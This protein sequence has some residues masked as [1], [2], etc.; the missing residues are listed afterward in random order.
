MHLTTAFSAAR[1]GFGLTAAATGLATT[2]LAATGTAMALAL[3]L[4]A[5]L[6]ADPAAA[7]VKGGVLR[8]ALETD[9][10]GF[11][12][13][14]GGVFGQTGEIVART[15]E[16]PLIGW[17]P[18]TN[19]PEPLLAVSWE[20][21]EDQ[22][23]WTFKLREGVKYHDGSDF[24]AEDV[25]KHYNRILDPAMKSRSRT[26]IATIQ[27]VEVIDD[28]TVAFHLEHPWQALLPYLATTSMSGPIPASEAVEA[29]T[30]NR[31]PIG[32]GPFRFVSW[33]S[34]DR[35]VVERFE[36][37]WN[38]DEIHLDGVE[39]RILPDTQTRFAS[40]KSGEVDVMW[41]DRGPSIVQAKED[42]SLVTL[43]TE[44]AGS[45]I[46]L[47]NTRNAPLDDIRVRQAIA[48]AWNQDALVKISWQN[49]RPSVTHPLGAVKDCGDAGYLAYD[50]KKAK[51]LVADY[52]E[53]IRISMIHTATPRGREL[54]EL[55][56]QML[57]QVGIELT[58][59]PVDQSTLV[60]RTFKRDFDLTGWR[61][62]DGADMGPQ[63]FALTRSDS[64]YNLT[65]W[66]SPEMDEVALAMRTALTME[67]RLDKQCE[68]AELINQSGSMHYRG[69]GRYHAF[70]TPEVK[71]VPAP[72]RGV[73]DVTRAWIEE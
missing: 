2:G 28:L 19:E 5:G 11:D 12:T 16:E 37:Y 26:F 52:G 62:A 36:D 33:T 32:T 22:K 46:N 48:H 30:Q 58:L 64:S 6:G 73:V 60:S 43:S 49:T 35:I 59:E 51:E 14:E 10:R 4:A 31:H 72:Y 8:V 7:Q 71:N 61:I 15:I 53:P 54:G 70:T 20:A 34:G 23:T 55:M 29:G 39:F 69:G 65:G 17:N 66:S 63:M 57:K 42:D 56:Q 25:A 41:T 21:S 1:K 50:P 38:K 13:V 40:L 9:V 18:D 44:G 47:V 68:M 24:T 3:T 45:A 27:N 67:E